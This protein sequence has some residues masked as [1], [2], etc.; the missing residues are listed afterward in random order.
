[1]IRVILLM[2]E[3][4]LILNH[5]MVRIHKIIILRKNIQY[6]KSKQLIKHNKKSLNKLNNKHK[7]SKMKNPINIVQ[8]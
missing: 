2:E 5:S 3:N 8:K 1:M 7:N 4:L 6:I